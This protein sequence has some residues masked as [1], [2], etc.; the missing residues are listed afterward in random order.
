[1]ILAACIIFT[2][3]GI[4]WMVRDLDHRLDSTRP[5][6]RPSV[7]VL[8]RHDR[9]LA[10]YGD[11]HGD[12]LP[13]RRISLYMPLA[14]VAIEDRR[15]Y[16][17]P[18]IDWRGI[19]R[20]A[21][22]N[23]MAGR[24]VQGG[25]TISQQLAKITFLSHERSFERKLKEVVFTFWLEARYT[26][27]DL[28][29]AYLNRVYF[30]SGAYGVASA[31]RLYFGK[32]AGQLT[33][34][35]AAILAGVIKAPSR[36][37]PRRDFQRSWD[38]AKLVLKSMSDAG[39]ITAQQYQA[40]LADPPALS[41]GSEATNY[42]YVSDWVYQ[43]SLA[44]AA[45][46]S[47]DIVVHS[48]LDPQLQEL[49]HQTVTSQMQ[50][51]K[52]AIEVAMIIM[53]RQGSVKALVGGRNYSSSQF[54]RAIQAQRQPGSAFK[55]V[56][57]LTA[58]ERGILPDDRISGSRLTIDG[59]S[60][61][62]W[63]DRYPDQMTVADSFATSSNTAAVRL[64]EQVGRDRVQTMAA[65]VGINARLTDGPSLALGASTSSLL[66]MTTAY[67]VIANQGKLVVPHVIRRIDDKNGFSLFSHIPGHDTII[68]ADHA[69]KMHSMLRQVVNSGT[70]Q[71]A[72]IVPGAAGKTGTSSGNRDAVFIGFAGDL[73]AGVWVGR[74]DGQRMN[75]VS[76]SG[77][78]TRIWA[79]FM[80]NVQNT[81]PQLVRALPAP[82]PRK[83]ARREDGPID[84]LDVL[85]RW[86][87]QG[88]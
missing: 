44:Y 39:F 43:E 19:A 50:G 61:T 69:A 11:V 52:T 17:H 81:R 57:Y 76:G 72:A 86:F 48:T 1:M 2:G 80:K 64:S 84:L 63:N 13:F 3:V 45:S 56:V 77:L 67:A 59:W 47:P 40:A 10:Q 65:R 83:P 16:D 14:A 42:R 23:I 6:R 18:G 8:D 41:S 7:I 46:D 79:E 78:P 55:L 30:G 35:E 29:E 34:A 66:E 24:V 26:K 20:A 49:A 37:S 68:S 85:Q 33:L 73:V 9:H 12:Y 74:D 4:F 53:D 60:P 22:R 27:Q 62:N 36:L 54:N 87:G 58:L 28:L 21:T 31:A 38:R 70:G 88:E 15:F 32:S 5:D 25:S 75:G 82:S 51:Y 71:L